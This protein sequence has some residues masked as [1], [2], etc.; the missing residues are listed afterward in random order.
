MC[1]EQDDEMLVSMAS[2]HGGPG[3]DVDVDPEQLASDMELLYQV[4]GPA[5]SLVL[6]ASRTLST[7]HRSGCKARRSGVFHLVVDAAA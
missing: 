3:A 5:L 4:G 6:A 7:T 2:A 1:T